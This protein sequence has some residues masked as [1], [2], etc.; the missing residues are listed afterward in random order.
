V[1]PVIRQADEAQPASAAATQ[2]SPPDLPETELGLEARYYLPSTR[3]AER[4]NLIRALGEFQTVASAGVLARIF[5]REKR[6]DAKMKVLEVMADNREETCR[7]VKLSILCAGVADT[8]SRQVR[9]A[10][11]GALLDVDDPRLPRILQKMA[12][13]RDPL[14]RSEAA[15]ALQK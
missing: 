7:E 5:A 14:I 2:A 10:A 11:L 8:Q 12:A 15:E 13:D 6:L 3:P 1:E 4:V 9:L